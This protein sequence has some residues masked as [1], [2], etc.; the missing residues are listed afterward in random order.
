MTNHHEGALQPGEP[1]DTEL[2]VRMRAGDQLAFETLFRR[3]AEAVARYARS[4]C[5][6]EHAAQDLAAEVFARTLHA[7]RGGAEKF[8][9]LLVDPAPL[10]RFGAE[11]PRRL[12]PG[13]PVPEVRIWVHAPGAQRANL[14]ISSGR[15]RRIWRCEPHLPPLQFGG[16]ASPRRRRHRQAWS[17]PRR[18]GKCRGALRRIFVSLRWSSLVLIASGADRGMTAGRSQRPTSS[19]FCGQTPHPSLVCPCTGSRATEH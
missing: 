2:I 19:H 10:A 8:F 13:A 9:Q 18:G 4:C 7:V 15:S 6:D 3:H 5:R 17:K 12:T 14:A 11:L 16:A 1:S